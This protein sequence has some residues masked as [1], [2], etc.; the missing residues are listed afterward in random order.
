MSVALKDGVRLVG[1][2]P[3]LVLA[4]LVVDGVCRERAVACVVTSAVDSTH[5]RGSLHYV[6]A[7]VD[8]RTRELQ[9][10]HLTAFRD[11]VAERLGPEYDVVLE[12]DHLH[13]EWQPKTPF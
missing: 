12:A 8:F 11:D 7:A 13:V 5:E 2:Q 10:A 3:Q 9:P 4:V 1:L 6:G